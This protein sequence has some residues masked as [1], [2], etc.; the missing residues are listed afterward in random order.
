MLSVRIEREG[1]REGRES[2][3]YNHSCRR[4][5]I[6]MIYLWASINR[7]F[8][9]IAAQLFVIFRDIDWID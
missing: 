8:L 2:Q 3:S 5:A 6:K 4:R 1:E 7:K 9:H